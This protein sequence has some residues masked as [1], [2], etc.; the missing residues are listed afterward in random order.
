MRASRLNVLIFRIRRGNNTF[1]AISFG[2]VWVANSA[3]QRY[4]NVSRWPGQQGSCC[5]DLPLGPDAIPG[6]T[7]ESPSLNGLWLAEGRKPRSGCL[8][9][10]AAATC[11]LQRCFRFLSGDGG[12]TYVFHAGQST[13]FLS[14]IFAIS[15]QA[16]VANMAEPA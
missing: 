10:G 15:I 16:G 5:V 11:D 6:C 12:S 7:E 9:G 2:E 4:G 14:K 13:L 8:T 3:V 1:G